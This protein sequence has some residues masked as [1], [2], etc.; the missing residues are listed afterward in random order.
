[1]AD[2]PEPKATQESPPPPVLLEDRSDESRA[3][4]PGDGGEETPQ[5]GELEELILPSSVQAPGVLKPG[6]VLGANGRLRVVEH[7]GTRG[8][9]NRYLAE[10]QDEAGQSVAAELRE[11]PADEPGLRR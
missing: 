8:R 1:M 4:P 11:G 9:I 5:A 7:R 2:D 3:A 6:T 10:W